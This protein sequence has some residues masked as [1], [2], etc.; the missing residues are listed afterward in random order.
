LLASIPGGQAGARLKAIDGTVPNLTALPPGCSFE[1][2]CPH[3]MNVCRTRFPDV[4]GDEDHTVR[5]YLH[6][7]GQTAQLPPGRTRSAGGDDNGPRPPG[8]PL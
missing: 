1:P 3:R 5:C 6:P 7:P 8:A 4:T 2:R